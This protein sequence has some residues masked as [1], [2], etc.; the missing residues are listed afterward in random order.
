MLKIS[1]K[2][3]KLKNREKKSKEKIFKNPKNDAILIIR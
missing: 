2:E 3:P 1:N